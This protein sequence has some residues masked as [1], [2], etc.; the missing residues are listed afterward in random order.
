M[1]G[2]PHALKSVFFSNLILCDIIFP[3]FCKIIFSG[4]AISVHDHSTMTSTSTN[5]TG[6]KAESPFDKNP[7]CPPGLYVCMNGFLWWS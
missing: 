7:H 5:F 3:F 2:F 1:V 6:N 4:G